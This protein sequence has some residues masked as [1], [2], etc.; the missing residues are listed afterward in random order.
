MKHFSFNSF[1]EKKKKKERQNSK[2]EWRNVALLKRDEEPYL[3]TYF[4]QTSFEEIN[5]EI[6]D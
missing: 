4:A 5:R 1:P 6:M 2:D 3:I